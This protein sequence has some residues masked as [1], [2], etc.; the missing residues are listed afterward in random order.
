VIYAYAV[1][2]R[3]AIDAPPRRR[4]LG[5][6][7]LRVT[8]SEGLAVVYSRHRSLRPRPAPAQLWAHERTVEALMSRGAVLPMRFG[9]V[10]ADEADLAKALSERRDELAAGLDRVGRRVELGVRVF[11]DRPERPDAGTGRA[12]LLARVEEHRAAARAARAVHAPLAELAFDSRTRLRVAPGTVFA[13]AYLVERADVPA[14]R[15]EVERA[16]TAAGLRAVCTGPWP[17]YSFVEDDNR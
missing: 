6:A 2:R 17:A 9:T 13:A 7:A 12:Y 1:C 3:E 5:G 10:L 11:A 14:F 4:G 8:E 15:A 16:A